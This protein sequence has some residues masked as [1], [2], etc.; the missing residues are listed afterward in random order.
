MTNLMDSAEE[1]MAS[2]LGAVTAAHTYANE[3]GVAVAI[4]CYTGKA[5]GVK[6]V[7]NVTCEAVGQGAEDPPFTG[8]YWVGMNVQVRYV[9]KQNPAGDNEAAA[10]PKDADK[11]L[12]SA[13]ANA[14][15]ADDLWSQ[16]NTAAAALGIAFTVFDNAVL[17]DAPTSGRDPEGTWIDEFGLRLYCCAS[18]LS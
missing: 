16:L 12:V 3:S 9:A 15:A 17:R 7:P 4:P 6:S 13:V 11:S 10:D 14:L 8:N 2:L 1:A 18:T 5:S